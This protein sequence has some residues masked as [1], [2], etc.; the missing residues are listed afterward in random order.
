MELTKEYFDEVVKGLVTKPD[1]AR[2]ATGEELNNV[3]GKI[4]RLQTIL[5]QQTIALD[6]IA[7]DVKDW[8]TEIVAVRARLDRHDQWFK[9]IS[10]HLSLKLDN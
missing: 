3:D 4:D 1:L 6:A 8:N 5:D 2:L 7:R 10:D 9:Q